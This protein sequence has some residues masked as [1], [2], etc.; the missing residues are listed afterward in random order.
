MKKVTLNSIKMLMIQISAFMMAFAPVAD[1]YAAQK[2]AQELNEARIKEILI[3]MGATKPQ[4]IGSFY[5]K[6][7]S[8]FPPRIQKILGELVENHKNEKMPVIE[9]AS[10][11][12]ADGK[13]VPLV[14][15]QAPGHIFNIEVHNNDKY[16]AK[17]GPTELTNIDINNFT[18][19]IEKMYHND[20]Q[21]RRWVESQKKSVSTQSLGMSVSTTNAV[22]NEFSL[23]EINAE[24]WKKMTPEGRVQYI[25]NM[26]NMWKDAKAVLANRPGQK[27]K[28][29]SKKNIKLRCHG[30]NLEFD[31]C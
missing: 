28:S 19:A 16:F 25:L 21:F 23:P 12:G 8:Q 5:S 6:N 10:A 31:E 30:R 22:K 18:D 20:Y 14:R 9:V 26:R 11:K 17:V 27:R 3:G 1:G 15:V 2:N 4:T 24:L 29:K 13:I 7:K